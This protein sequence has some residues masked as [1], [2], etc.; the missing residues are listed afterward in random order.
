MVEQ[1]VRPGLEELRVLPQPLDRG[2]DASH[3][4]RVHRHDQVAVQEH[5]E[6]DQIHARRAGIVLDRARHHEE[7]VV[8][9]LDLGARLGVLAVLD[10]ERVEAEQGLEGTEVLRGRVFQIEPGDRP[11]LRQP[12]GDL[13]GI[14]PLRKSAR[15]VPDHAEVRHVTGSRYRP[16]GGFPPARGSGRPGP[17]GRA[18]PAARRR[19]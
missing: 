11:G 1:P 5:V 4:A 2:G 3:R 13:P 9:L 7:E 19:R 10:G 18:P 12:R 15:R 17:S 6:R 14:E 16:R 8:V